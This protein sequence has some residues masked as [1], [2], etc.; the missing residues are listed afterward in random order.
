LLLDGGSIH[1]D[2]RV[3]KIKLKL[4]EKKGK[5]PAERERLFVISSR[6]HQPSE[7][8][9]YFLF[10][11]TPVALDKQNDN[12]LQRGA[13][14]TI[15]FHFYSFNQNG[16]MGKKILKIKRIRVESETGPL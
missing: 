1:L 3:E 2:V 11:I 7:T 15:S 4:N 5:K 6:V 13:G 14:K 8:G 12:F 10:C 16:E 9:F